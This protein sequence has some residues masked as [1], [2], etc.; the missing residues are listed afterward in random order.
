MKCFFER[1]IR[2]SRI[3]LKICV[4]LFLVNGNSDLGKGCTHT[5][6]CDGSTGITSFQLHLEYLTYS[7]FEIEK[8]LTALAKFHFE[9]SILSAGKKAL[10]VALN[11]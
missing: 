8:I 10:Y 3:F 11:F 6:G 7:N 2:F 9:F 5:N 4:I 1:P